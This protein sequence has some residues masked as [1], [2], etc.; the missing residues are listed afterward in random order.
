MNHWR[1]RTAW[2]AVILLWLG[3][4]LL[5]AQDGARPQGQPVAPE[6]VDAEPAAPEPADAQAEAAPIY[7]IRLDGMVNE[8]ML[9]RLK[10]QVDEAL[11]AGAK[12]MVLEMDTWGGLAV[13]A[14][15]M[16][17]Y[18]K[19]APLHTVAWVNPKAISA[20]AMISLATDDIVMAERS[21]I[22]DCM[23]ISGSGQSMGDAER[24]KI[25]TVVREEFR[26]SAR[27]NGYPMA[28]AIAMVTRGAAIYEIR[29][30]QTDA[31]RYVRRTELSA[32]G[33]K[34][35]AAAAAPEAKTAT[36]KPADT[37]APPEGD[38]AQKMIERMFG[39]QTPAPTP[40]PAEPTGPAAASAMPTA[41]LPYDPGKWTVV[42]R[43][44]GENQLLTMSQSE[45]MDYGFTSKIVSNPRELAAHLDVDVD[46]FVYVAANWSEQMVSFLTN[47]M[48]RGLL[49]LL[50]LMG[51][52]MEMQSPGLGFPGGVALVAFLVL[53]GAPYLAGLANMMEIL[54]VVAGILLLA[55]EVFVLPG[56]GVAGVSGLILIFGGLLMTFVQDGQGFTPPDLPGTWQALQ[57]GA[58][59]LIISTA[60]AMVGFAFL[61]RYFGSVP[62]LNRLML[63]EEQKPMS[64]A[65]GSAGPVSSATVTPIKEGDEG[66]VT[67]ELHP[68]GRAL[69]GEELVDVVS[70][71]AWINEGQKVR[72]IEVRGNRIVVEQV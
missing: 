7:I 4:P 39:V 22:G 45:A 55:V 19:N 70:T 69:F 17:D 61:T 50:M 16:C 2:V 20:G 21:R 57:T 65:H 51:L 60:L 71:G 32:Y 40:K 53:V 8:V 58:F 42:R 26:D 67:V 1:R 10:R 72:V 47:P 66:R 30:N 36:E 68:T 43:V 41:E 25:E 13:S 5:E 62:L 59:T 49:T 23:P 44:V 38:Q 31:L 24:E 9:D 35:A 56:F 34:E 54:I 28:L 14:L 52:Y 6:A 63:A 3:G 12:T 11:E 37:P 64:T 27:R 29:H 48:M 18:I 46:R 15:E 33:V